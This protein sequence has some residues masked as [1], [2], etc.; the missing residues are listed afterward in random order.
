MTTGL[1]LASSALFSDRGP[2][3]TF[4]IASRRTLGEEQARQCIMLEFRNSSFVRAQPHFRPQSVP[5][6][7]DDPD[8]FCLDG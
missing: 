8:A 2:R 3:M 7:K 5:N 6:G 1:L 4:S